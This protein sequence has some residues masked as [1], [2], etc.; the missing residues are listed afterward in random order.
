MHKRGGP[1]L[2]GSGSGL[3]RRRRHW[4]W[5]AVD[6]AA[7][8]GQSTNGRKQRQGTD[9]VSETVQAMNVGPKGGC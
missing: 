3:R 6:S 1:G 9:A 5:T 7:Q 2:G 8:H 4:Q